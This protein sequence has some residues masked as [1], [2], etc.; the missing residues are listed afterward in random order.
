MFPLLS[1]TS[2]F[3][4]PGGRGVGRGGASWRMRNLPEQA[5][6]Q[7]RRGGGAWCRVRSRKCAGRVAVGRRRRFPARGSARGSAPCPGRGGA[8]DLDPPAVV[9]ESVLSL[10][11]A[12]AFIAAGESSTPT[13]PHPTLP[14]RF[15][16]SF[17][18]CS[19]NYNKAWKLDAHLCKHTGEVRRGEAANPG[20]RDGD[21]SPVGSAQLSGDGVWPLGSHCSRA[22]CQGR[23]PGSAV[24]S[25][26]TSWT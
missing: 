4:L 16:C 10:T 21:G 9:A 3:E 7:R 26:L 22:Q 24:L 5:Q 1:S 25:T 17:P 13:P 19:A 23:R 20:P 12:D 8:G 11:V 14:R 2:G 6:P 15:I 18:D